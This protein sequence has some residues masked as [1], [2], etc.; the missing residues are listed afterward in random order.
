[1]CEDSPKDPGGFSGSCALSR[2]PSMSSFGS[3]GP[4]G[5]EHREVSDGYRGSLL[6]DEC[7]WWCQNTGKSMESTR[8][9]QQAFHEQSQP[10][11]SILRAETHRCEGGKRQIKLPLES[12]V[13][14]WLS[15]IV[16]FR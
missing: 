15:F 12:S 11:G 14:A 3:H 7:C 13:A 2:A 9:R 4:Q 8:G 10:Y 5:I 1:M 16:L 6:W